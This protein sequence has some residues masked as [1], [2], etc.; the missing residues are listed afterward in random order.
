MAPT[1]AGFGSPTICKAFILTQENNVSL[2]ENRS[3]ENPD[4]LP[5][6]HKENPRCRSGSTVKEI[7]PGISVSRSDV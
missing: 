2:T 6:S 1:T 4:Q 5:T 7:F 3:K